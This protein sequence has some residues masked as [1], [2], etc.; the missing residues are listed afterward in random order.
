MTREFL[1]EQINKKKSFLCVGL[2]TDIEKIPSHLKTAADAVFQF[3]KE[4]IDATKDLCVAY[5]INT[6]FYEANGL[7]GWEAL[8]KT[9]NYILRPSP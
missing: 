9:L 8:E 3:N 5:K 2:D 4:I 1:I 7:K 6:A